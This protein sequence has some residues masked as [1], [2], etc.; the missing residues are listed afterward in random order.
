MVFAG[1][2]IK[3]LHKTGS[4]KVSS[5][6]INSKKIITNHTTQAY[7]Y[8]WFGINS[9]IS[10]FIDK[11]VD[12]NSNEKYESLQISAK[13]QITSEDDYSIYMQLYDLFDN[14]IESKNITSHLNAGNRTITLEHKRHK[15]KKQK[16]QRAFCPKAGI[17]F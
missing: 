8:R 1:D 3:N 10:G 6:K 15:N 7:D 16:T 5:V 12:E 9:Y 11:G 2:R 4:F 14:F 17:S 13:T